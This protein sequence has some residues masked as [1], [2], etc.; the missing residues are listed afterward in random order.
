MARKWFFFFC[1]LL[2]VVFKLC[3]FF[4]NSYHQLV[5]FSLYQHYWETERSHC[6]IINAV[7]VYMVSLWCCPG[8]VCGYGVTIKLLWCHQG[9]V[10]MVSIIVTPFDHFLPW[11]CHGVTVRLL[12]CHHGVRMMLPWC[13]WQSHYCNITI[14]STVMFFCVRWC[15]TVKLWSYWHGIMMLPKGWC[16]PSVIV[17]T[18][19]SSWSELEVTIVSS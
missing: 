4:L 10:M 17:I 12:W 1:F 8:V 14:L 9:L 2:V 19:M 13:C 3:C 5:Q 15:L 11:C 6:S 7:T 16:H 18:G